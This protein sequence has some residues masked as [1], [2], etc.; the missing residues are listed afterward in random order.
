MIVIKDQEYKSIKPEELKPG[1]A[2]RV[3][4]SGPVTHV[5]TQEQVAGL[6]NVAHDAGYAHCRVDMRADD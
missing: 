5:Y 4:H 2:I 6:M 1:D 3:V